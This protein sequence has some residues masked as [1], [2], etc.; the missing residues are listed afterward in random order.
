MYF[1]PGFGGYPEE[2]TYY[3]KPICH[4]NCSAI[5]SKDLPKMRNT[6]KNGFPP[7]S[8]C[9]VNHSEPTQMRIDKIMNWLK[10]DK[11]PQFVALYVENPDA[12][13]HRFV[14]NKL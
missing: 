2:P 8:H 1:W 6:T 13:G 4:V 7:Y 11:P 14:I 9:Q 5:D 3:E 10:A 12:T